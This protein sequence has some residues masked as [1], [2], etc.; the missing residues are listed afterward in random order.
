MT[1]SASAG[2]A[3]SGRP[4]SAAD[5]APD[6]AP[7]APAPSARRASAGRGAAATDPFTA[8]VKPLADAIGAALLAPAEARGD[9]VVLRW[10]GEP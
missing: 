3:S 9:D 8:A 6:S 5:S 10:E 4:E 7:G 2:R 1:P